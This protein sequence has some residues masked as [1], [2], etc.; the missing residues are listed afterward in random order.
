[1]ATER[2]LMQ[3]VKA[4][5]DRQALHEVIRRHSMDVARAVAE[6]GA[7]NDLIGR[8]AADPAF[9]GTRVSDVARDLDAL[10]Y[11]G[12]SPEQVDEFLQNVIAPIVSRLPEAP[13]AEVRV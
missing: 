3:G 8:L 11:V 12:R 13:A 2:C 1:M 10:H 5:G 9:R 6:D 4:G 7:E